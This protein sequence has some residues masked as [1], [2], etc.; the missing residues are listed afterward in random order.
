MTLEGEIGALKA[1]H[2]AL[3]LAHNY[4]RAEIQ[5]S[6]I[7]SATLWNFRARRRSVTRP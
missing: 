4:T 5:T 1:Q 2:K 6:P 7:S 3:I